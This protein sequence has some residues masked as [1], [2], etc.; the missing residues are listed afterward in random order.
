MKPE[1]SLILICRKE[2][3]NFKDK[4]IEKEKVFMD[5]KELIQKRYMEAIQKKLEKA[6]SSYEIA[7]NDTIEA[8]G[9]MVTRYD[10]TKTETAWLADGYL[11]EVKE[12]EQCIQNLQTQKEYANVADILLLDK[13]KNGEYQKTLSYTLLAEDS[14]V[15]N[16]LF[17]ALLGCMV[18]DSV[19]I[20]SSKQK[21]E[22]QI[23]EIQK[24]KPDG[25]A[26]G[27]LITLE[28]EYGDSD[29]YYIVNYVGGIEI[30]A[31][32]E[33]I[34]CLSKQAPIA[35]ALLGKKE[36]DRIEVTAKEVITFHILKVEE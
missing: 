5:K 16:T 22:Y 20:S 17:S 24:G 8:E 33:I 34:Y 31:E 10:S 18:G 15:S 26:I 36:G 32:G 4:Q 25:A 1:H 27:S 9:R 7:K 29:Q 19:V 30:E 23:R 35:Q 28:D 3:R 2:I 12:L 14:P 11:K 21:I 6:R 13:L